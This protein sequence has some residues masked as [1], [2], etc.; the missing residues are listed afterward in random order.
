MFFFFAFIALHDQHFETDENLF[1]RIDDSITLQHDTSI[2][3]IQ[4]GNISKS[5]ECIFPFDEPLFSL[6][7]FFWRKLYVSPYFLLY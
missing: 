7:P 4:L 5:D 6:E 2:A 3:G 1:C